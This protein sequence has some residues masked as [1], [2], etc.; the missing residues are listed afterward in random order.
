[1]KRKTSVKQ[2]YIPDNEDV[3]A[4]L[5]RAAQPLINSG[6]TLREH[7]KGGYSDSSIIIAALKLAAG[8]PPEN[9][10]SVKDN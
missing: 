7:N 9:E 6:Y 1:M 2:F 10:G 8:E 5:K 3:D 4:L